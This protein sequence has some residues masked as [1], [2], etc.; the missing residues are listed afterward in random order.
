M[1][2]PCF[3]SNKTSTVFYV[4]FLTT[5]E[6]VAPLENDPILLGRS[7]WS[8]RHLEL[9]N[10][11]IIL[12]FKHRSRMVQEFRNCF[13]QEFRSRSRRRSTLGWSDGILKILLHV[14]YLFIFSTW[15]GGLFVKIGI[16]K[17]PA[18]LKCALLAASPLLWAKHILQVQ[19]S[20][21]GKKWV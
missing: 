13:M 18:F 11:S 19:I 3:E 8:F 20:R 10:P 21:A 1:L 4:P 12:D 7:I 16:K 6:V 14:D 15:P 5:I 9:Q 2:E 17:V